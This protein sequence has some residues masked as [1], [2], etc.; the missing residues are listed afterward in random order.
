MKMTDESA[1]RFAAGF[2][3]ESL[4]QR[5]V[6]QNATDEDKHK[7]D[8]VVMMFNHIYKKAQENNITPKDLCLYLITTLTLIVRIHQTSAQMGLDVAFGLMEKFFELMNTPVPGLPF[9][10]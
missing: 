10:K 7:E 3:F 6:D 4:M 2:D 9:N 5:A 8:M 1:R